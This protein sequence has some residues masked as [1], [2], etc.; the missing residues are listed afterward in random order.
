MRFGCAIS[1]ESDSLAAIDAVIGDVVESGLQKADVV[2]VF[3]TAAHTGQAEEILQKVQEGLSPGCLIGASAEGVIGSDREVERSTGLALL[4]GDLDGASF[5]S[6]HF[7]RDDWRRLLMEDDALSEALGYSDQTRAFIGFGDPYSTPLRQLLEK[8]E[9]K[10]PQL[11]LIGGMASSGRSPGE[12]VLLRD[13]QVLD[14]G[15]VGI[16]LSGPIDVQTVVSQGCRPVGHP[17]VVTKAHENVIEQIAGRPALQVLQEIVDT[18]PREEQQLLR[19]GLYIGRAIDEY[20][21]SWSRGDFLVRNVMGMEQAT[22]GIGITDLVR[23][24]QTVQFHVRDAATA[25]EDLR[26]LLEEQK[27]QDAPAGGLLFNC[28]GRGTRM[29]SKPCHDISATRAILPQTPIAGFFAAGELGPVGR[30][31]FIHGHTASFALFRPG[32]D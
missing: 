23:A 2:F 5:K 19:N 25:E 14:Q 26:L 31:N 18:M 7:G 17:V 9:S 16:S 22:G 24:G 1:E 3:L 30:R 21:E 28:N 32:R 11:P 27:K 10:C 20:R 4:A 29:F 13:D 12:N 8:L 6:F 15:F